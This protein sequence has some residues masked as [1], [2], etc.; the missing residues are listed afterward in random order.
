MCVILWLIPDTYPAHK[1]AFLGRLYR[2][3]LSCSKTHCLPQFVG[4]HDAL[5]C[6]LLRQPRSWS[7]AMRPV[8]LAIALVESIE[9]SGDC[10]QAVHKHKVASMAYASGLNARQRVS[11]QERDSCPGSDASAEAEQGWTV[12]RVRRL[13][14]LFRAAD[15]FGR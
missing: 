9:D 3:H 14:L 2:Q 1:Q 10:Q 15:V 12:Q 11:R 13:D 6:S 4:L 8:L 7:P 5:L